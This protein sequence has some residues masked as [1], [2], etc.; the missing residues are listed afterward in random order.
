MRKNNKYSNSNKFIFYYK[1]LFNFVLF[2]VF[3]LKIYE[4]ETTNL[5]HQ[6]KSFEEK[7]KQQ[8]QDVHYRDEQI[9]LVKVE[10]QSVQEKFKNKN[11]EVNKIKF[12]SFINIIL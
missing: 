8:I 7:I 1:A 4:Q 2:P 10:L 9:I 11:D 3:K 5:K 6:L 12:L